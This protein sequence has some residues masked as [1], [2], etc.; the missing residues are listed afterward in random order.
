MSGQVQHRLFVLDWLRKA[1]GV[2]PAAGSITVEYRLV[3]SGELYNGDVRTMDW[4]ESDICRVL[5]TEPFRLVVASTDTR[6]RTHGPV[7]LSLTFSCHEVSQQQGLIRTTFHPHEELA[8][9]IAAL[10]TVLLRRLLTVAGPLRIVHSDEGVPEGMRE[11]PLSIVTRSLPAH[12]PN[13]GSVAL[14]GPERI[15]L[16]YYNPSPK[17]VPSR[18]TGQIL[19]H[20]PQ[21]QY[22]EPIILAARLYATAMEHIH[23][24]ADIAYLMLTFA[25]DTLAG[26]FLKDYEADSSRMERSYPHLK[27]VAEGMG[28]PEDRVHQLVVAACMGNP[29]TKVK[30]IRFLTEHVTDEIWQPDEEVFNLDSI[31]LPKQADG[32]EKALDAVFVARNRFVHAGYP[33]CPSIVF[34]LGPT[35]PF[36][37]VPA[38]VGKGERAP[39]LAWFERV[40]NIAL[41]RFIEKAVGAAPPDV[42]STAGADDHP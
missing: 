21:S 22:A 2:E 41:C 26:A 23:G 20:L 34:G 3:C 4:Q 32:L 12:W 24:R 28:L 36:R 33:Y 16:K 25:V 40:V 11:W 17:A 30:F 29:W 5:L 35:V 38:L 39:A 19:A 1:G 15:T 18:K 13:Q 6:A 27:K 31:S 37:A 8:A 10:L 7:E 42:S 14:Y 9:D